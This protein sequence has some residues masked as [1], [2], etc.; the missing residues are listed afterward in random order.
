M[1]TKAQFKKRINEFI[2]SINCEFT[3]CEILGFIE[4]KFELPFLTEK[5]MDQIFDILE[6]DLNYLIVEKS[7]PDYEYED[8]IYISRKKLFTNS[9]F[10]IKPTDYELQ[11]GILVTGHRFTPFCSP[12]LLPDKI[13]LFDSTTKKT[14]SKKK[15]I[16][17][18]EDLYI[19]YTFLGIEAMYD[20]LMRLKENTENLINVSDDNSELMIRVN[21]MASFYKKHSFKPGD[22]I[23]TEVIDYNKG[24]C[25]IEYLP[26]KSLKNS[27]GEINNW[28][29]K[30]ENA[31]LKTVEIHENFSAELNISKQLSEAFY[32]ADRTLLEKPFIH[33]GGFLALSKKIHLVNQDR[34]SLLWDK[35][36]KFIPPG[37][38]LMN[39]KLSELE[40]EVSLNKLNEVISN[41]INKPGHK[42]LRNLDDVLQHMGYS[43]N[44]DELAAYMRDELFSGNGNINNVK[45]RCFDNRNI[46]YPEA[47][48]KLNRL[49]QK[50]WDKIN[51]NYN[52]FADKRV[53]KLRNQLL[54]LNDENIT[55]QRKIDNSNGKVSLED[56]PHEILEI[57]LQ[58]APQLAQLINDLNTPNIMKDQDIQLL[59]K[60]MEQAIPLMSMTIDSMNKIVDNLIIKS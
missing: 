13:K 36:K 57:L 48:E 50:L 11:R 31:I 46:Y 28:C 23:L 1:P 38:S 49:T 24:I 45:S 8:S 34:Y 9:K 2:E 41:Q 35:N 47:A 18:R 26:I 3:D 33:L 10:L 54:K 4:D 58:M 17:K 42:Q 40:N 27:V 22:Y 14:V 60:M 7:I 25:N 53:G 30:L 44:K 29:L 43:I 5:Q 21:N 20:H 51:N 15:V 32:T 52:I 12:H 16:A 6:Y 55:W 37:V 19:Y 56:I 59:E 39:Q